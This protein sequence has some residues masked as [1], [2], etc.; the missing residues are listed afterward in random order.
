MGYS[1]WDRKESDMTGQLST[2]QNISGMSVKQFNLLL[3]VKS[4][5]HRQRTL[6]TKESKY[7]KKKKKKDKLYCYGNCTVISKTKNWEENK[8]ILHNVSP[9]CLCAF[10]FLQKMS[11]SLGLN[12]QN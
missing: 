2:A 4:L 6:R 10:P 11:L 7:V 1:P 3:L 9:I 5:S 8:F 12:S